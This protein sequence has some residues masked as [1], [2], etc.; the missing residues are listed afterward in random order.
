MHV[1]ASESDFLSGQRACDVLL[2]YLKE[3]HSVTCEAREYVAG[4]LASYDGYAFVPI[5]PN[6]PID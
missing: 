1:S 5:W 4:F 2:W 3:H 6:S